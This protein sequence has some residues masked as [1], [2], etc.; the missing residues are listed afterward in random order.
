MN[1]LKK[2]AGIFLILFASIL[3]LA[4][5]VS[6]FKSIGEGISETRKSGIYGLGYAA[7]SLFAIV[8]SIVLI[9]FM[10]KFG[11]KL[12]KNKTVVGEAINETGTDN[13]IK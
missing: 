6:G 8:L 4:T 5:L 9:F 3:S 2:L 12:I 13:F 11:F 1:V 7:G 10:M